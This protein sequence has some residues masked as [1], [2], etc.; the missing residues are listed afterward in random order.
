MHTVGSMDVE[1]HSVRWQ[2][3][4]DNLC[5][6][7]QL[8]KD[9]WKLCL[10]QGKTSQSILD[11]TD[12]VFYCLCRLIFSFR[13]FAHRT[14]AEHLCLPSSNPSVLRDLCSEVVRGLKASPKQVSERARR[15]S[16]NCGLASIQ[17]NHS[18]DRTKGF[19]R[20]ETTASFQLM[21]GWDVRQLCLGRVEKE[22]RGFI[23]HQVFLRQIPNKK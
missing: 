14:E 11:F 9:I 16:R 7:M 2:G 18:M 23:W 15:A 13:S 6:N 22:N 17:I 10:Q 4:A 1:K 3:G 19:C 21:L 20:S 8:P 5:V 12:D